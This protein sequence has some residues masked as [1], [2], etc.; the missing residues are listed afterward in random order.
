MRD[1]PP[2]VS[3]ASSGGG[4]PDASGQDVSPASSK[5]ASTPSSARGGEGTPTGGSGGGRRLSGGEGSKHGEDTNRHKA[6]ESAIF[7][8]ALR[9]EHHD[10]EVCQYWDRGESVCVVLCCLL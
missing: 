10:E 3:S 7:S 2:A 9:S 5:K 8:P 6:K 4:S 1:Y